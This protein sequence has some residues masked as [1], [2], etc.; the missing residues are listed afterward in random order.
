VALNDNIQVKLSFVSSFGCLQHFTHVTRK[1][2]LVRLASTMMV[3]Q[4]QV[5]YMKKQKRLFNLLMCECWMSYIN[6]RYSVFSCK[7]MFKTQTVIQHSS[8]FALQP[9]LG[10]EA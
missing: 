9:M 2:K 3:T 8:P 7:Y 1:T 10:F 6:D 5:T 4:V